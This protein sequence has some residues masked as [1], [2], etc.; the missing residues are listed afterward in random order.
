MAHT[1]IVTFL[2]VLLISAATWGADQSTAGGPQPGTISVSGSV[3]EEFS[4]DTAVV[5]LAV[6]TQKETAQ[7]S[8]REN[9]AKSEKVV[10]A[11]KVLIDTAAGDMVTTSSYSVQPA[12]QYDEKLRKN[13]VIGY[14]TFNQV[15]VKTARI[16]GVGEIIDRA[17]KSGANNVTDIR[18][19]IRDN[20]KQCVWLLV[21]AAERAQKDAETV[22]RA[23]GVRLDGI[24]HITPT[25]SG[26]QRPIPVFRAMAASRAM[27]GAEPATPVEAG[28]LAMTGQVQVE[29]LL[30]R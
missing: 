23:L 6:E 12:Y 5:N 21:K 14:R 29:F 16:G 28:A 2:A 22:A 26:D 25:C 11:M 30:A 10:E 4:P 9:A 1:G 17:L 19:A 24:R 7:E 18:F 8:A 15:T 13:Q 20:R 27:D 3:T